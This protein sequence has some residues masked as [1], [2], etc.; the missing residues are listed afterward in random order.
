M[1]KDD[2]GNEV[3]FCTLP[4]PKELHTGAKKSAKLD[5]RS[6]RQYIF[7]AIEERNKKFIAD[8]PDSPD[9]IPPGL[10]D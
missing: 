1:P 5:R 4:I 9:F 6:L 7:L 3:V 8:N 10:R 2:H